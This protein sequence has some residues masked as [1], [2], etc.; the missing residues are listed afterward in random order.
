MFPQKKARMYD[1][2][3][4][5]SATKDY[6]TFMLF[7][8]TKGGQGATIA[9]TEGLKLAVFVGMIAGSNQINLSLCPPI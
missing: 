4:N 5:A 2:S 1:R 9:V 7:P 6:A 8:L 3:P